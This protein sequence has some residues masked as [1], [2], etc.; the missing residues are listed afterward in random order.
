MAR[1][2]GRRGG[3]NRNRWRR[4]EGDSPNREQQGNRPPGE[5]RPSWDL[6]T[7]GER[8][9]DEARD[10][11]RPRADRE[12]EYDF[13]FPEDRAPRAEGPSAES[14]DRYDERYEFE[15][16]GEDR[17][18]GSD[19]DRDER[20]PRSRDDRDLPRERH[21]RPP[22]GEWDGPVD[23]PTPGDR[24]AE[25]R[26][27]RPP[28]DSDDRD[29][30]P[31]SVFSSGEP[32]EGGRR[33]RRRRG[34]RGRRRREGRGDQRPHDRGP[35]GEF[36]TSERGDG[37]LQDR[38]EPGDFP[39][40]SRD[41][42][43]AERGDTR[44]D[45]RRHDDRHRHEARHHGERDRGPGRRDE[46]GGRRRRGRRGRDRHRDEGRPFDD[47]D[48][49][50]QRLGIRRLYPEQRQIIESVMAGKDTLVV[51]PTGFGKSACYQIPSLLLPKPVIVI[52]PLIALMFDQEQKLLAKGV[53]VVRIDSTLK[54]GE[55]REALAKI[56]AGGPM[57]IMTTPES[58][59]NPQVKEALH[60]SGVGLVA[61]DEAHCVS[62]WG[63]DF[64]PS[65]MRIP[66]ELR[67]LENPPVLALTATATTAVRDS[68][69]KQLALREPTR[70]ESSPHRHNLH[71]TVI[72][73]R[74]Y[75]RAKPLMKF[76]KRLHRPGLIYCATTKN[77]DAV[78]VVL[79][80]LRIPVHRYHGKMARDE[81]DTQ[82]S[83]FM[84]PGRKT[85]MVG[86]S[87]FGLGIDMPD[88]H[89]VVHFE[90]PASLEQYV[91]EAGRA[92]RDGRP[93]NCILLFDPD[94]REIH[95]ALLNQSRI[96]AE[97]VYKFGRA[98]AEWV[99]EGKTP[100]VAALALSAELGKRITDAVLSAF[101]QAG[102]IELDDEKQIRL[103]ISIGSLEQLATDLATR[104]ETLR[105]QDNRRFDAL[106]G[107]ARAEG[108]RSV[109]LS[110]YFGETAQRPCGKCDN[111]KASR[112]K[113]RETRSSA[114]A[115][116]L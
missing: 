19:R 101:I 112:H 104:F 5:E 38:R 106:L 81:R 29:R 14:D 97:H 61:V 63:H 89:F 9:P 94:D 105:T 23:E 110:E 52:S 62:E 82:Q 40:D 37:A 35:E 43:H 108:C 99:A 8:R 28:G 18:P 78:Y 7:D 54:V 65:Y 69:I 21:A 51:L 33:R 56:A 114:P 95:Q 74:G 67:E 41:D 102:L 36:R 1:R 12:P 91:Q 103:L 72:P 34:G 57:L 64:R 31:G 76:I 39:T 44:R 93:A 53:P 85:V 50:A 26:D 96:R 27:D 45:E 107:Y 88:V 115:P 3:R 59:G 42:R 90:S 2:R 22:R 30:A 20:E 15:G 25:R 46:R 16:P 55:R 17:E 47:I 79:R 80:K 58:L 48:R 68:I 113:A 6:S 32:R 70:V 100:D 49:A 73:T 87:A 4:P 66:A 13:D 109:Y 98:L 111:C 77:V 11:D 71:F 83:M 86:T 116:A 75:E 10:D 24:L 60:W 84:K 92:G